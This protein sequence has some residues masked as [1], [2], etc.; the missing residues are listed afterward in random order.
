MKG[1]QKKISL[2]ATSRYCLSVL[3]SSNIHHLIFQPPLHLK[4]QQ[5]FIYLHYLELSTTYFTYLFQ[6]MGPEC[7]QGNRANDLAVI[8]QV[9]RQKYR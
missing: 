8:L 7:Y 3:M 6:F 4:K 1:H 2:V 5:H 9:G